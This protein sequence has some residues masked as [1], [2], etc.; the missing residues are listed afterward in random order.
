LRHYRTIEGAAVAQ[1]TRPEL[2]GAAFVGAQGD[3]W[4]TARLLAATCGRVIA[5]PLIRPGWCA[6]DPD[7][8]RR[9]RLMSH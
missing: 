6:A 8:G 9:A 2:L 3:I 7:S 5:L 4:G 1:L